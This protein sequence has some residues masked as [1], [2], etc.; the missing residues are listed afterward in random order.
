MGGRRA[1]EV[2]K[3][4]LWI[5]EASFAL[6]RGGPSP[7]RTGRKKGHPPYV[8]SGSPVVHIKIGYG[9]GNVLGPRTTG[10]KCTSNAVLVCV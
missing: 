1:C 4:E 5:T 3:W 8:A 9:G 6:A 2:Q 10:M 7:A